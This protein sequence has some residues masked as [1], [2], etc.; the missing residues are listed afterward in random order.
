M[1]RHRSQV[2]SFPDLSIHQSDYNFRKMWQVSPD[3]PYKWHGHSTP[4]ETTVDALIGK[5]ENIFGTLWDH[6]FFFAEGWMLHVNAHMSA[7]PRIIP[8][9]SCW[10]SLCLLPSTRWNSQRIGDWSPVLANGAAWSVLKAYISYPPDIPHEIFM[11]ESA[12]FNGCASRTSETTVLRWCRISRH[13]WY[14]L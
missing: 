14:L 11:S 2:S 7:V 8:L 4:R 1:K 9:G 13:V 6:T 10:V 3:I 5:L 12:F